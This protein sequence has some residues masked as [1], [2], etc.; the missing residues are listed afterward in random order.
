[1]GTEHANTYTPYTQAIQVESESGSMNTKAV[2]TSKSF[3]EGVLSFRVIM[4]RASK[5]TQYHTRTHTH[6]SSWVENR[7][8]QTSTNVL[9]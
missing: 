3:S 1:M 6:T 5:H 8:D 7:I 9:A 2:H 4:L